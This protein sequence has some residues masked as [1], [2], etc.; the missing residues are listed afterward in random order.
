[1]GYNLIDMGLIKKTKEYQ[2][3]K[4]DSSETGEKSAR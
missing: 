4:K 1:M 3:M 2:K